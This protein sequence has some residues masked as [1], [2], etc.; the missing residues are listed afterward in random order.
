MC[1]ESKAESTK[2]WMEDEHER[3]LL[4]IEAGKWKK[5]VGVVGVVVES[6]RQPKERK[7][8]Q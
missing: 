2:V 5:I 4:G 3:F 7:N 8:A 6:N 1:V